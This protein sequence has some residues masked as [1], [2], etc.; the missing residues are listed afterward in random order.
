MGFGCF[1]LFDLALAGLSYMSRPKLFG[2]LGIA[3]A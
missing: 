2:S 1:L 3:G